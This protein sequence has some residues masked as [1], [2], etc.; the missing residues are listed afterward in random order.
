MQKNTRIIVKV[1][2]LIYIYVYIYIFFLEGKW[3]I[4]YII[5]VYK[6]FLVN[7]IIG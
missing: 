7:K 1:I 2:I 6:F 4:Q 5:L 3:I